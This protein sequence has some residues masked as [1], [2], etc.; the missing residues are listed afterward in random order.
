[1]TQALEL[2]PSSAV[3]TEHIN[4]KRIDPDFLSIDVPFLVA[5]DAQPSIHD[6]LRRAEGQEMNNRTN[7]A[8]H[9]SAPVEGWYVEVSADGERVLST[10]GDTVAALDGSG[11]RSGGESATGGSANTNAACE[12]GGEA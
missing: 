8:E 5:F 9:K 11:D 10:T 6:D 3:W 7:M 1:M 2:I 4:A 12:A